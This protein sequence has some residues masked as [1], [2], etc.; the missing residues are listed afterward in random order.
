M[1]IDPDVLKT[2]PTRQISNGLAEAVKMSLTSDAELFAL[3]EH[4]DAMQSLDTVIE[5]SLRIKKSVVEQDE[6]ETGLRR[7]LNFGHT[8]GHGVEAFAHEHG[9]YHGECVA[10]GMLPMCAPD[11]RVRLL[12]VLKNLD[13]PTEIPGD[14]TPMLEAVAHDKKCAGTSVSV[15]YVPAVGS[16]EI[17]K[18]PLSEWQ[19]D[20]RSAMQS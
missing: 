15:V 18:L 10:I 12:K 13:L 3:F 5:R 9:L 7:I 19:N 6:K 8:L 4:G 11:V 2:L 17:K 16:F 1:L 14:L 20:I